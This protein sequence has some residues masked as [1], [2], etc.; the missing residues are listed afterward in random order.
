MDAEIDGG[1]AGLDG[2]TSGWLDGW[3][4]GHQ[5]FLKADRVNIVYSTSFTANNLEM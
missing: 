5:Y 1:L 4:D 3:M 2:W